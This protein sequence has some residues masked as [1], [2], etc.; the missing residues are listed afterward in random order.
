MIIRRKKAAR[1]AESEGFSNEPDKG[2]ASNQGASAT[3]PRARPTWRSSRNQKRKV[4]SAS[5]R[6]TYITAG[7]IRWIRRLRVP[8]TAKAIAAASPASVPPLRRRAGDP[9]RRIACEHG[10]RFS[11]LSSKIGGDEVR[12]R[13][14][15]R[16]GLRPAPRPP[17]HPRVRIPSAVFLFSS[18]RRLLTISAWLAG[19]RVVVD[20][21]TREDCTLVK[22]CSRDEQSRA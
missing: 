13:R 2:Y 3:C 14:V 1:N 21:E 7:L 22:V 11:C 8:P 6:S 9:R 20:N 18:G 10:A 4:I 12:L 5:S 19:C 15:L 16:A 17:R